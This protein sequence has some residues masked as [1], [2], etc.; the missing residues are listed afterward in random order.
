MN[1]IVAYLSVRQYISYER[2]VETMR[3]CFN[4]PISQVTI[5]NIL[6]N[7]TS[8]AKPIYSQIQQYIG[9]SPVV[10]GDKQV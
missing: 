5:D 7:L 6:E 1:A 10:G 2:I 3:D 9:K 4:L 8:K